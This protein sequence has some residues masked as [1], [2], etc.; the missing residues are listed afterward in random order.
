MDAVRDRF[1]DVVIGL[2]QLRETTLLALVTESHIIAH[3]KPGTGKTLSFKTIFKLAG[4]KVSHFQGDA[5]LRPSDFTGYKS[6]EYGTFVEGLGYANGVLYDEINRS[7][8]VFN[9]SL[10]TPLEERFILP[11]GMARQPLP[12]PYVVFA[13]MNPHG[14]GR[15]LNPIPPALLNRFMMRYLLEDLAEE[16]FHR[17]IMQDANRRLEELEPIT[18]AETIR[19]INEYVRSMAD[20]YED[21]VSRTPLSDYI[22]RLA[23]FSRD[24]A[25]KDR[26]EG[27]DPVSTRA[28]RSLILALIGYGVLNGKSHVDAEDVYDHI[29]ACWNHRL[30]IDDVAEAREVIS[31]MVERVPWIPRR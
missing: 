13:T 12:R 28:A 9:N 2:D 5:E 25:L 20:L 27:M 4:L 6:V 31:E 7:T 10:L 26:F 23:L 1:S 14:T 21:S 29:F 30:N 11:K 16:E 8:G 17:A 22:T 3:A 19:T 15:D 24:L 18:S